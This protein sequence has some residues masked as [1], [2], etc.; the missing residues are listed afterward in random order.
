MGD[1]PVGGILGLPVLQDLFS[2]NGA[3][4]LLNVGQ[5]LLGRASSANNI[6]HRIESGELK[7]RVE[8]TANF[9]R[10]LARI[11]GQERKTTRAILFGSFLI[12][13]TLLYVNG[14]IVPAVIGYGLTALSYLGMMLSGE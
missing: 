3:K 7:L 4:A 1:S 14:D 5:S 2:G 9:Q 11:E 12:A 6:F 10:Q 8:P 13:S